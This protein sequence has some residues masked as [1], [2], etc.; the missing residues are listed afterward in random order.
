[1]TTTI[2]DAAGA[3]VGVA[4]RPQTYRNLLYLGL[5]FPLGLTYF[6]FL[7]VGLSLGVGLAVTVVGIPILLATLAG[8]TLLATFEAGRANR[9]LGTD[10][11]THSL[12]TSGGVV[13]AAKR[14]VTD[15]RTWLDVGYLIVKLGLGTASFAALATLLSL[16]VG[17]LAAPLTYSSRYYVG[18]RLGTA[19]GPFESVRFAVDTFGEAVVAAAVG[20]VIAL[21]S[22]HALNGLA[23]LSGTITEALLDR[24]DA[25]GATGEFTGA[26]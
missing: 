1:M 12:D 15:A 25:A 4:A 26:N 17:L 24:S 10:V 21:A 8:A 5:A 23:R 22:L 3:L 14:L 6:V 9:L 2:R 13:A 18:L 7:S 11:R 16:A 19:V 20:L